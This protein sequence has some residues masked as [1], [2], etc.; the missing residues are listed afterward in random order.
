[1]PIDRLITTFIVTGVTHSAKLRSTAPVVFIL[2]Q[3]IMTAVILQFTR[4]EIKS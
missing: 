4:G 3:Y 2:R 1:M